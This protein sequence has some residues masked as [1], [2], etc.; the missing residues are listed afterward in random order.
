MDQVLE[1]MR[2]EVAIKGALWNAA[3]KMLDFA[4]QDYYQDQTSPEKKVT[5]KYAKNQ[6][7]LAWE[8]YSYYRE[9]LNVIERRLGL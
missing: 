3:N 4:S 9:F 5:Y 1:M 2:D 8:T 7:K 6:A